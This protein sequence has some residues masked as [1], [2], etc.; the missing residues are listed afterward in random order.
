MHR[1]SKR[2]SFMVNGE[3]VFKYKVEPQYVDFIGRVLVF[4]M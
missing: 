2:G 3:D 4:N 1:V